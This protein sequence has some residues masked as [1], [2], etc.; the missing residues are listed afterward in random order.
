ME[1]KKQRIPT[2]G[3]VFIV[4]DFERAQSAAVDIILQKY[5]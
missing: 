5:G 1:D 3:I 4:Y 2:S